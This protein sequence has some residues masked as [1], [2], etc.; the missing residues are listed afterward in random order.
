[1][2]KKIK[3]AEENENVEIAVEL[4]KV[5]INGTLYVGRLVVEDEKTFLMDAMRCEKFDRYAISEYLKLENAGELE[6]IE[7]GG[8]GVSFSV[9][10]LTEYEEM[11]L[12]IGRILMETARGRAMAS[13]ENNI[14][15]QLSKK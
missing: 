1:M 2:T 5:N 15:D 3:K 9:S 10:E 6:Q 14:F 11:D 12:K 13:V 8:M 4:K 7:F